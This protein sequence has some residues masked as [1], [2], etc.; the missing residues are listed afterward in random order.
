MHPRGWEVETVKFTWKRH[1]E[2]VYYGYLG[3]KDRAL[4]FGAPAGMM[5]WC[6]VLWFRDGGQLKHMA[7]YAN[8]FREAKRQAEKAAEWKDL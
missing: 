7:D 6:W 8:S 1:H 4:V 2:R 5:L 3:K